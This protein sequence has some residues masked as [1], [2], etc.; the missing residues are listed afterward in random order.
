MSLGTL[1]VHYFYQ[2]DNNSNADDAGDADL[3]GFCVIC[4]CYNHAEGGKI[5][6]VRVVRVTIVALVWSC[7]PL[8]WF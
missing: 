3:R 4:G 1:R 6:V 5:R 8:P 2:S 7:D